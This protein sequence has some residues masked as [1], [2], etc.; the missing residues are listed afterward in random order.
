M[1]SI[2]KVTSTLCD[3]IRDPN[4]I[5]LPSARYDLYPAKPP[6]F[7]KGNKWCKHDNRSR[8]R[9]RANGSFALCLTNRIRIPA[10]SPPPLSI[11]L[12]QKLCGGL[13]EHVTHV[14]TATASF[15]KPKKAP[16][17]VVAKFYDPLY[18]ND[19]DGTTITDPLR[20]ATWSAA[21]EVR[22]YEKL[23]PLQGTSIPRCLGLYATRFHEQESRTVYVLLL[24]HVS[25]KDLRYLCRQGD[26]E[27]EVLGDYLCDKHRDAIFSSIFQLAMDSISLGV[28]HED[29]APRNIIVRPPA[30]RGP[31]C[32]AERCPV[33]LAIDADS[34]QAVMVDLE[35][36]QLDD[37]PD[38]RAVGR[39]RNRFV[40]ATPS[41]YFY[42]WF[43]DL[44]QYP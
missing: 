21:S 20:L 36:V 27:Q 6:R 16:T 15:S 35:R 5:Y 7:P 17:T 11:T 22:A 42:D 9:Q 24:E 29:L 13:R 2:N 38:Q 31:F 19:S 3:A 10:R 18:F 4:A 33:R 8:Q 40:N 14:W 12:S 37:P 39:F 25:G 26:S 30:H 28:F 43:R 41:K 1:S 23:E 44:R 34:V 32:S